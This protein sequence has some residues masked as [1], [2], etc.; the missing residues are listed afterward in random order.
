MDEIFGSVSSRKQLVLGDFNAKSP[1]WGA[2]VV[3]SREEYVSEWAAQQHMHFLNNGT[4]TFERGQ[5]RS[6]IDLTLVSRDLMTSSNA[7]TVEFENTFT[8][9]GH[10]YIEISSQ[11]KIRKK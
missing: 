9:H 6:H 2:P 3:D 7:W 5:M 1:M 10:I 4:H 8:Y 11:I